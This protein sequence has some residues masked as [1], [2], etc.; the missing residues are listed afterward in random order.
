[1]AAQLAV[2]QEGLRSVSKQFG[3]PLFY[4]AEHFARL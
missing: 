1:V 4:F 3:I 2:S